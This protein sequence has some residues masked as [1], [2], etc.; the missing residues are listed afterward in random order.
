MS[1]LANALT[2][3]NTLDTDGNGWGDA[4]FGIL[5]TLQSQ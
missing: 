2:S 5:D 4:F 1:P 3:A